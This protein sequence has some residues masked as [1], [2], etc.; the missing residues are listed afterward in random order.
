MV[1]ILFV[2]Q[3]LFAGFFVAPDLIPSWLRWAQYLC[4][5][6][7]AVRIGLV[8]EFGNCETASCVGVLDTVGADPDE[9]WL[10]WLVL[11][12]LF[13]AFRMLALFLLRM[14]ATKFY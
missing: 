9:T 4:C 8:A 12:M 10:Y 1:P 6:T 3:M 11:C 7:Y 5:L 2:P 14:K 13:I